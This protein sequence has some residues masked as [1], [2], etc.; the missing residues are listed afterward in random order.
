[1]L[2]Y[3][4]GFHAGNHADVLKH[5]I[6]QFVLQYMGEKERPYIVVD[7]MLAQVHISSK[8]SLLKK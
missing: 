3:R 8:M 7:T 2:S 1:M 4:H 6:F 5:L